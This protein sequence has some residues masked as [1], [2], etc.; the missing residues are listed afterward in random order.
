MFNKGQVGSWKALFTPEMTKQMEEW[1]A[2]W[3]KDT[4]LKFIYE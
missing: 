2:K 4:D 1:E 3:L